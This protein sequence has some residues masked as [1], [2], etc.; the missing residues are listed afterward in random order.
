[1]REVRPALAITPRLLSP[2]AVAGYLGLG[3][4]WS[5]YRL[6]KAGELPAVTIA[7]KLRIDREDVDRMIE[8]KKLGPVTAPTPPRSVGRASSAGR[9]R[10]APL[11]RK[12]PNGDRSVT[13]A[14]QVVA[15]SGRGR[16]ASDIRSVAP[17]PKERR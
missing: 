7:G 5:V 13:V 16:G 8:A 12:V 2:D 15:A 14:A 17:A 4:R 11:A 9:A 6:L 10:L 1:V 3:S